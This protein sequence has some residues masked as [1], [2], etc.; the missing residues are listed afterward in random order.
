MVGR[1]GQF[2]EVL[3]YG[4]S[5]V[6]DNDEDRRQ[7]GRKSISR[8]ETMMSTGQSSQMRPLSEVHIIHH[9]YQYINA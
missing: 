9:D 6:K 1:R 7:L 8:N 2:G 5:S 3:L 4:Q